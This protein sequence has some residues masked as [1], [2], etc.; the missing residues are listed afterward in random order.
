MTVRRTCLFCG[1][2]YSVQKG[3]RNFTC[4]NCENLHAAKYADL[5]NEQTETY[6]RLLMRGSE[7]PAYTLLAFTNTLHW[8]GQW[9]TQTMLLN[10]YEGIDWRGGKPASLVTALDKLVALGLVESTGKP[11][12]YTITSKGERVATYLRS[13]D[14]P[15][16]EQKTDAT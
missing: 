12:I 9:V 5:T 11:K 16:K 15:R 6:A 14:K 3:T 8:R 7:K 2:V 10:H 1:G 4:G 13:A